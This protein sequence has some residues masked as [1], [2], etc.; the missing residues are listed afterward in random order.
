[1]K[2]NRIAAFALIITFFACSS[3]GN[4]PPISRSI[5]W[6]DNNAWKQVDANI[7]SYYFT[8]HET[9]IYGPDKVMEL[10]YECA[11]LRPRQYYIKCYEKRG[12]NYEEREF[13]YSSDKL[14]F[15]TAYFLG[16]K[17]FDCSAQKDSVIFDPQSQMS[18]LWQAELSQVFDCLETRFPLPP[19]TA[20][21]LGKKSHDDHDYDLYKFTAESSQPL[22]RKVESQ[23][24]MDP[25]NKWPVWI[26]MK[27]E[28]EIFN[29]NPNIFKKNTKSYYR[30][31]IVYDEI[32]YNVPRKFI[33]D[34][35]QMPSNVEKSNINI[36]CSKFLARNLAA[37][38]GNRFHECAKK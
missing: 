36:D 1:M 15:V 19:S 29:M 5:A 12:N 28:E 33:E 37:K 16:N 24:L 2:I 6:G 30:S 4:Q 21:N 8:G 25:I 31:N 23:Y 7:D 27:Y 20:I 9:S 13:A 22:F 32:R 14:A 34:K 18:Y 17:S 11:Y 26:E 3:H 10:K 38:A 35:F